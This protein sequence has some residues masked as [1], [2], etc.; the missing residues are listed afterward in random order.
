MAGR[1]SK[2]TTKRKEQ[3]IDLLSK[4]ATDKDV[5]ASVGIDESTFYLWLQDG[6]DKKTPAK[7]EFLD[8]VTRA[9]AA[10]R[11]VAIES[12]R[13]GMLPSQIVMERTET[14]RE[15]RVDRNGKQ[16]PYERTEVIKS[17]TKQPGDWRAGIEYLKRRDPDH[18]SE[19]LVITLSP[20]D[21]EAAR[22]LGYNTPS[23]AA[24]EFLQ[25]LREAAAEKLSLGD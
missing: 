9:R 13:L 14:V 20:E 1:Q 3:I 12:V 25:I 22:V 17:I 19:K 21:L 23:E 6:R 2:L 7:I 8:A 10:A 5:C 18:W 15:T 11:L 4:G 16:Y 24:A